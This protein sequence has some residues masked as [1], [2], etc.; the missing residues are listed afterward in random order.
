[1][2]D[3]WNFSKDFL[4]VGLYG[5]E[6]KGDSYGGRFMPYGELPAPVRVVT[7]AMRPVFKRGGVQSAR[8]SE[9][10]FGRQN[11]KVVGSFGDACQRF[12]CPPSVVLTRGYTNITEIMGKMAVMEPVTPNP[13]KEY[14]AEI[15]VGGSSVNNEAVEVF[16]DDKHMNRVLVRQYC[17]IGDQIFRVPQ[18]DGS[19]VCECIGFGDTLEEAQQEARESVELVNFEGKTWQSD[20]FDEMDEKLERADKLGVGL[21]SGKK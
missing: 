6:M 1:M 17:K 15:I 19:L 3:D 8:S 14:C 2:G 21:D 13:V 11:G 16:L 20:T 7:D 4:P 10:R 18:K 5:A 9:I 12:G